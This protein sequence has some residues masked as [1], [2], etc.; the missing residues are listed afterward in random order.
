[1]APRGSSQRR[2]PPVALLERNSARILDAVIAVVADSGWSQLT[3]AAVARAADL[4]PRPIQDRYPE[5]WAM[6]GAAWA[7]IAGPAL[8]S[9]LDDLLGAA[10]LIP[11][12]APA[13]DRALART[14]SR[15]RLATALT[16]I[17]MLQETTE[18][19]ALPSVEPVERL[20]A[21][22]RQ[23]LAAAEDLDRMALRS[24]GPS[25]AWLAASYERFLRPDAALRAA[26]EFIVV[27]Q[28]NEHLAS[29]VQANVG[30][31]V[32]DLCSTTTVD[33]PTAARRAYVIATA[34]GLLLSR[35]RRSAAALDLCDE[36]ALHLQAIRAERE[37]VPLPPTRA[38]HLD[39]F[40][41]IT[42]G[43]AALDDLLRATLE[44]V[45]RVGYE[46]ATTV[47]IGRT[48]GHSEGLLFARYPSKVEAFMDATRRQH[49]IG[50]RKNEEFIGSLTAEHGPGI[51]EAVMV[52]EMQRPHLRL[53]RAISLEQVRLALHDERL[54]DV[55]WGE[56]DTLVDETL[57]KDPQWYTANSEAHLH[58]SVAIG[59]GVTA[60]PLLAPD[61]WELPYDVVTVPLDEPATR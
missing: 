41:D 38:K 58:M 5:R 40:L 35:T 20:R 51:A 49:A 32:A 44:E 36:A 61:A 42:T 22:L 6:A 12:D 54:R 9:A 27:S 53:G 34:L 7:A 23:A 13:P 11:L 59:I 15:D 47:A 39:E 52:R 8:S 14:D 43:E 10:G 24:A 4:S 19:A 18:E 55:Q 21:G 17:G 60:L 46:A 50:W 37:P 30:A 48:S 1:M 31:R 29:Q 28:F 3:A 25:A 45:G 33:P 26:T 56:L 16:S 57:S 2:R